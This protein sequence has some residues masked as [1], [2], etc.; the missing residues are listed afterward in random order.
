MSKIFS[1][2]NFRRASALCV[3][4]LA[5]AFSTPSFAANDAVEI[6]RLDWTFSGLTGHFDR[7]QLR[8]GF[9]VYQNVCAV[10][11]GMRQLSYR[12]LS[13]PGG[14]QFS[15]ARVQEIASQ[16]QVTDGPND[17][18]EMFTRPGTPAD[19]FVLPFP[20]EQAAAAAQG[21][22]VPPDLSLMAKARAP[23]HA[24]AWY[25]EPYFWLVDIVTNYQEGGADYLYALLTGYAD[26]PPAGIDVLPGLYYNEAFPGH[27]IA[28]PPPLAD[29]LVTY[30]DGTPETVENY[31]KD[32][33][34]FMMWAAEPR[35]E[36]RKK[37]G[38]SVLVYLSILT[39]LLFLS[40]R[41]LWRRVPH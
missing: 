36:E 23:A 4:S 16:A 6:P 15:Q 39:L 31:A 18:G 8:R 41:A 21:G 2:R 3:V 35:M 34:A 20:N 10:C 24:H 26:E 19:R 13:E 12:N 40:K 32:V 30:E 37:M 28:M 14:P 9:Q 33:T 29:G 11:H 22:S 7:P 38:L 1:M 27:Q 25:T 17:D 5:T